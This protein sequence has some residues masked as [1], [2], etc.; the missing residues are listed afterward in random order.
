MHVG[1]GKEKCEANDEIAEQLI[2][3]VHEIEIEKEVV[4]L[5]GEKKKIRYNSAHC[6]AFGWLGMYHEKG[7]WY[8]NVGHVPCNAPLSHRVDSTF[9]I[10]LFTLYFRW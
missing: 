3:W 2:H 7:I 1:T 6:Y 9:V 10:N 4:L 5:K 8:Y